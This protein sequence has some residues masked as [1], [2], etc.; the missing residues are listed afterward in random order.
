MIASLKPASCTALILRVKWHG[1]RSSLPAP[2][3]IRAKRTP[4]STSLFF[5]GWIAVQ[6]SNGSAFYTY[7]LTV[8]P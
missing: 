8:F 7:P 4:P 5:A 6:A 3:I 2:L 1:S